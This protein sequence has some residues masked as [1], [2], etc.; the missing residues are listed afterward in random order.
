M[1]IFIVIFVCVYIGLFS[2]KNYQVA[3]TH[4]LVTKSVKMVTNGLH[5][6][7]PFV[8]DVIYID[9]NRQVNLVE[10][11]KTV[12]KAS[13]NISVAALW[14]VTNPMQYY[15][16]TKDSS[17]E[18]LSKNIPLNIES[19]L[20]AN[21]NN[22]ITVEDL[23]QLKTLTSKPIYLAKL[24]VSIDETKIIKITQLQNDTSLAS[25]S[26]NESVVPSLSTNSNATI[27]ANNR[28]IESIENAYYTSQQI[29]DQ[30]SIEEANLYK[31]IEN[32]DPRF[33]DYFRKLNI[34]VENAKSKTEIPSLDKLY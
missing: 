29:L 20:N 34:Y 3:I 11:T 33:Y 1:F 22:I 31:T 26:S 5:V 17:D 6:R 24:G 25:S 23:N 4:N 16:Y 9:I 14:H 28:T 10:I 7:S 30:T 27:K 8:E 13:Y 2:V 18:E 19:T 15:N 12:G 32:K 21:L